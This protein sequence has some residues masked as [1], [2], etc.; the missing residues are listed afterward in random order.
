MNIV[1]K[2][3]FV[4]LVYATAFFSGLYD[5]NAS[6]TLIIGSTILFIIFL[7]LDFIKGNLNFHIPPFLP[8]IGDVLFIGFIVYSFVGL[9][10]FSLVFMALISLLFI[11]K[12]FL[13]ES[14]FKNEGRI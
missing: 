2:Y 1:S 13:V 14:K 5:S 11:S 10:E 7:L 3:S 9:F 6:E 12:V 8:L 4:Y